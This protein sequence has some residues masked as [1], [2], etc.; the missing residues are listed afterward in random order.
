M[1]S[2]L[3]P[4]LLTVIFTF[5]VVT[6]FVS[7]QAWKRT[8]GFNALLA[9]FG[10]TLPDGAGIEVSMI[11]APVGGGA[12]RPD[13][14]DAQFANKNFVD[15]SNTNSG[16]SDHANIVGT[17]FYGNTS[18]MAFGITD[19]TIYDA[20]DW[21]N[22]V[23]GFGGAQNPDVQP[24][25]VQNH[26]YI[27]NGNPVGVVSNLL[28]R[29]DFMSSSNN[30]L[31]VVGT[32]N[33]GSVPQLMA[34]GFNSI[35][36]GRTDGGH[37]SGL[38]TF[39]HAGRTKP[40]IVGAGGATSFATPVV[41]GVGAMLREGAVGTNAENVEAI[42]AMI[43]AGA[44]KTEFKG[45]NQSSVRPLDIVFGTGELCAYNSYQILL[46]GETDGDPSTPTTTAGPNGWDFETVA[47]AQ[48]LS[49][50]IELTEPAD[51]MSIV[52]N[53]DITITDANASPTLFVPTDSLA[54]LDLL[55]VGP[56]GVF[57]SM[58]SEHNTEHLYLTD[59]PA[60]QYMVV[61]QGDSATSQII[62]YG[63]AWRA[64]STIDSTVESLNV[65]AGIE[66]AGDQSDLDDSD[67]NF[68][69]LQVVP[70]EKTVAIE[71][72]ST[73]SQNWV[74]GLALNLESFVSTPNLIRTVEFFNYQT[75]QFEVVDL[76]AKLLEDNRFGVGVQDSVS[77]PGYIMYSEEAVPNRF[78]TTISVNALHLIAVRNVS[79]QWQ[80]NDNTIW[81]D[82]T[83]LATDRLIAEVDF[84]ANT[85]DLLN[86]VSEIMGVGAGFFDS[87]IEI[88]PEQWNGEPNAGEFYVTGTFFTTIGDGDKTSENESVV[89][90]EREL[91]D[92]YS[93]A[94]GGVRAR[95]TWEQKGPVVGYPWTVSIDRAV[96]EVSK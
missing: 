31:T 55:V 60:G 63:L 32:N 36:V 53:W 23:T 80:Y 58:S 25:G 27:S 93:T 8:N 11:E 90:V 6:N 74:N 7:A 52:L 81:R 91:A 21:L 3:L 41:S 5:G 12:Y 49:Y 10:N 28:Q 68:F 78:P 64:A 82:F 59:L 88:F 87:D 69:E 44:T 50:N 39:Y 4:F 2:R 85:A 86:G 57:Q 13:F 9:E 43:L 70:G 83:P 16:T 94:T 30:M 79:G 42:R 66:T 62:D 75:S 47:P 35:T 1:V 38:T 77:G 14:N 40:E 67:N 72:E 20:N 24:F 18:G 65:L 34:P 84:S 96:F 37:A 54:D 33:S 51:H 56:T 76:T 15:G 71:C 29:S 89:N 26:S 95:V 46:G 22:N 73:T 92:F 61:V 17:R 48:I 45:W 19:I